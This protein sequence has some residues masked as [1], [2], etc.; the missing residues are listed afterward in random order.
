MRLDFLVFD[1]LPTLVFPVYVIYLASHY[2]TDAIALFLGIYLYVVVLSL[3]NMAITIA[4][5]PNRLSPFDAAAVLAVPVYQGLLLRGARCVA[6]VTE[7]LFA[8]SRHDEFVPA[9]VRRA[10]YGAP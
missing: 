1:V 7:A 3:V 8:R 5:F 6:F 9:K 10:L 2:G 4:T